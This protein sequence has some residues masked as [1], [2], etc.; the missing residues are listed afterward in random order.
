VDRDLG[1]RPGSHHQEA[2]A[3]EAEPLHNSPN[4]EHLRFRERAVVPDTYELRAFR[5]AA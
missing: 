2:A 5:F 1:L 4:S 3:F